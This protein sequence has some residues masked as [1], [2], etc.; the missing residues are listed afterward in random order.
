MPKPARIA[1]VLLA[2][3]GAATAIASST[4]AGAD[5]VQFPQTQ[6]LF[7]GGLCV[8]NIRVWA[9]TS[10]DYPGRAVMNVQAQ[11]IN[12]VGSGAYPLA[13]LCN[14]LTTVAW[15]NLDTGAVGQWRV[16][17]V[18][19]IYGSILY[20][21]YQNTGPGHVAATVTTNNVSAPSHATFFVPG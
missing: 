8:G 4:V 16:N 9:D 17:V 14:V 12:G 7:Y 10:P 15:R 20:A 2:S 5:T 11:P 19:G 18:A 6:S 13:P 1:A 21:L 3:L